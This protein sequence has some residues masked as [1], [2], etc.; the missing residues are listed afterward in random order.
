MITV[1]HAP[2]ARS[3]RIIWTLE[4]LGVPYEVNAMPFTPEAL[5]SDTYLRVHPL[6]KVPAIRDGDVRLFESGAIVEY[7]V[8]RYGNGRLAPA[9]NTPARPDY[10]QWM[11]FAEGTAMPPI[12]ELAQHTMFKPEAERVPSVVADARARIAAWLPVVE[13]ALAGRDYLCG[14]EFTAADV[15][16]GYT[17]LL[18][19]W[20]GMLGEP[21]ANLHAWL[22]RLEARPALQKALTT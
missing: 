4:E 9:P 6:G 20:F 7:L 5:K 14:A 22:A 12:S 10:L 21:H 1:Y 2:R 16:M 11:H 3:V 18:P 13:A 19:K 17:A 8:E 15:M